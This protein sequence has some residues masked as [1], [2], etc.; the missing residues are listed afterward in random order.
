MTDIDRPRRRDRALSLV[1]EV[2]TRP[3]SVAESFVLLCRDQG[4]RLVDVLE[5]GVD[6]Y[7]RQVE[8]QEALLEL[9]RRRQGEERE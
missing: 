8:A 6:L 2:A 4:T 3:M 1:R 9:E 5:R 7:Q